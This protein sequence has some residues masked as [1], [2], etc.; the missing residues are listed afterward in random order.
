MTGAL[1]A[2]VARLN[3]IIENY[4]SDNHHCFTIHYLFLFGKKSVSSF[5]HFCYPTNMSDIF[6]FDNCDLKITCFMFYCVSSFT[7][8]SGIFVILKQVLKETLPA[9]D[10]SH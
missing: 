5:H 3:L 2:S 6:Q 8:Q 9:E 1:R 10:S 7:L 4:L